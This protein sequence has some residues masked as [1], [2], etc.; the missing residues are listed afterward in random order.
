MAIFIFAGICNIIHQKAFG[1]DSIGS[2]LI[3]TLM[4]IL[5][6]LVISYQNNTLFGREA[7]NILGLPYLDDRLETG[8]SVVVCGKPSN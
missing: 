8:D 1:C 5:A 7:I 2:L 4:A 3:S 6:G